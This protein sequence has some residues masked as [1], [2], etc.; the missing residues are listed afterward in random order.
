MP[1]AQ[2]Q[3]LAPG[4]PKGE[5]SLQKSSREE[6][7]VAELEH[8]TV[9]WREARTSALLGVTSHRAICLKP[10]ALWGRRGWGFNLELVVLVP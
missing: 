1:W 6:T 5:G 7:V 4:A 10:W 8:V 9:T 2:A 3:P